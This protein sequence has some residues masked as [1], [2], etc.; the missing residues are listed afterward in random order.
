MKRTVG[1]VYDEGKCLV[2]K[3][4]GPLELNRGQTLRQDGG[5]K[6]SA[7]EVQKTKSSS[8]NDIIAVTPVQSTVWFMHQATVLCILAF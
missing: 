5:I 4:A 7:L 8:F 1:N 2:L 6:L 3:R